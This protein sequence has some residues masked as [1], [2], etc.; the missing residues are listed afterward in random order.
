MQVH[1]ERDRT[2]AGSTH[3]DLSV[4][5]VSVLTMF[6][7][8]RESRSSGQ[9][10]WDG[11]EGGVHIPGAPLHTSNLGGMAWLLGRRG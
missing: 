5:T 11:V 9:P 7:Q 4:L 6:M 10:P 8:T 1:Q 3:R 2:R